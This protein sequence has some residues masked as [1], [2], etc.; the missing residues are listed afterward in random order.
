MDRVDVDRSLI[1]GLLAVK[2]GL[3]DRDTLVAAV[4]D[5]A[6]DHSRTLRS[7]LVER[8]ALAGETCDLLES[9]VA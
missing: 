4:R 3:L 2:N 9:L 5:W 1:A 7:A 6:A 8:G